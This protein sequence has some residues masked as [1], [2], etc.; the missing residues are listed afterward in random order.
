M[1]VARPVD[2]VKSR[3]WRLNSWKTI[4]QVFFI[5]VQG[6][7]EISPPNM[8]AKHPAISG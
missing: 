6:T 7:W 1:I 5:T 4:K 2:A 3:S 8:R